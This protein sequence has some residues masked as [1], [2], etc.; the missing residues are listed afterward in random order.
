MLSSGGM[1]SSHSATVT[2]LA[3]SIGL[4]EGA[5]APAFAIALVLACVVRVLFSLL[6]FLYLKMSL[7]L[8]SLCLSFLIN[9]LLSLHTLDIQSNSL[10]PLA[11][12]IYHT[13]VFNYYIFLANSHFDHIL[14]PNHLTSLPLV[15][16]V[17]R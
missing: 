12:H 7:T 10:F 3:L 14:K 11:S 4:E 13:L 1:P 17:C 16:L 9:F 2:A 8:F 15:C 6:V 5:G